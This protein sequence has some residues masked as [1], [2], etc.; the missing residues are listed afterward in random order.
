ME[1]L[2]IISNL[3]DFVFCPVSIYFHNIE[4]KTNVMMYQQKSQIDGTSKHQK[5]DNKEYSTKENILQAIDIYCE[6]YG[7]IGKIDVYDDDKKILTE[8]KKK[9]TTIYDGYIFQLYAQYFSLKDMGY[10]PLKIQLYSYD[11]NKIHKIL[12]PKDDQ[13]MF[14][15]FEKLVFDMRNFNIENYKATNALKCSNCIYEDLCYFS[16]LKL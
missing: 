11:D 16:C 2:I 7:L 15:K 3:N 14:G 10:N 13:V 5:V 4:E 1:N 8:R 6:K 9:I 12:L